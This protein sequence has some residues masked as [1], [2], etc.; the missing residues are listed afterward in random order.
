M[1]TTKSGLI[2]PTRNRPKYL[3]STLNFISKNQIKFK[4]IIVV[5]SSDKLL[6]ENIINICNKFSVDLFFSKPSTSKQ[7]NL[8]L[9][10]LEKYKLEFIMFLDDDLKFYKNSFQIMDLNIRKYKKEFIGFCFNNSNYNKDTL[11]EKIK[12]SQ[13]IEKLGLYSSVKGKVLDSG[14]HTKIIN[15]NRNLK[16]QWVPSSSVIFQKRFLRNKFFDNSFGIYSYLEDLDF[17]LQL[18]PERK[19][20]FLAVSSARFLHS[21]EI[22]RTSFIFGY[23]EFINRFKIVK[24]F[25]LSK[26][27]FFAMIICKTFIT[28]FLI[29][30]NYK[31]IPK[32][33]GNILAIFACI[34]FFILKK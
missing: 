4:K 10:K 17:S 15:L 2:I 28:M 31:N 20:C 26:T 8:G 12:L 25:R 29:L 23:Y 13:F 11:F 30:I 32:L 24:K 21:E 5:D 22:E 14:W 1:F 34:T 19:F 16:S 6:K 7:R 9:R 3:F 27:L 18:N 33:F